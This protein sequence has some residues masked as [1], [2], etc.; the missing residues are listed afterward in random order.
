MIGTWTSPF[1][2]K[3]MLEKK[4]ESIF[5]QQ[6]LNRQFVVIIIQTFWD[7]L[8]AIVVKAVNE[9]K[10]KNKL[11]STLKSAIFKLLRKGDKD[12][13]L[14]AKFRPISLLSAFYKITSCVITN[15]I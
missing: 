14:A 3:Q 9:C 8:A 2:Q 1:K 10:A 11:T 5:C 7:P 12:P 6:T 4:H 15:R 13:T